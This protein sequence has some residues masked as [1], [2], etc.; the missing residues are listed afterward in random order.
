MSEQH[1]NPLTLHVN[2]AVNPAD[3]ARPSIISRSNQGV[4][5]SFY[6]PLLQFVFRGV[7]RRGRAKDGVRND[8][9]EGESGLW[10]S[11]LVLGSY[12]AWFWRQHQ[13]LEE[14]NK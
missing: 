6:H 4:E 9:E 3:T 13:T 1:G 10:S 14:E 8:G 11:E 7:C 12:P 2:K 5:S